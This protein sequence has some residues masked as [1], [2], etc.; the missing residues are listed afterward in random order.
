VSLT[1]LAPDEAA[2]LAG[3]LLAPGETSPA[4]SRTPWPA[5]PERG[6]TKNPNPE[7]SS[8]GPDPTPS[9]EA[10]TPKHKPRSYTEIVVLILTAIG[11]IVTVLTLIVP[12]RQESDRAHKE[13]LDDRE[14]ELVALQTSS[15]TGRTNF[16]G[17]DAVRADLRELQPAAGAKLTA[18]NFAGAALSDSTFER[19]ELHDAVL[20]DDENRA[21]ILEGTTWNNVDARHMMA[22]RI[23]MSG[24]TIVESDLSFSNFQGADLSGVTF[25][26]VDLGGAHLSGANLVG[27][28]LTKAQNLDQVIFGETVAKTP[29]SNQNYGPHPCFDDT[30]KGVPETWLSDCAEW[31]A[32]TGS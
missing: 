6:P 28:D 16:V 7:A 30:T 26:D 15:S 5:T 14:N 31:G 17:I 11:L 32:T 8:S 27:A 10:S 13:Q 18:A 23:D 19:A 9:V 24:S 22:Q 29:G 2:G 3:T 25:V 1:S 21:A 4:K 20:S 12:M